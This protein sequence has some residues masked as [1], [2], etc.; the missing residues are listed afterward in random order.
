M[1]A[2]SRVRLTKFAELTDSLIETTLLVLFFLVPLVVVPIT[3]ELFEFNK[4]YLT[5]ALTLVLVFLELAKLMLSPKLVIKTT[6][7]FLPG[8]IFVAALTLATIFSI[9]QQVSLF[10]FYGRFHGGLWSWLAYG[11]IFFSLTQLSTKTYI[12]LVKVSLFSAL[13]VSVWG[14]LEHYGIDSSYWVQDVKARVFSTLG[15]PNWLAAYLAML[16]PWSIIFYLQASKRL[17]TLAWFSLSIT[18]FTCFIF[19]YSRGGNYGLAAGVAGL[20]LLLGLKTLRLQL[21]RLTLLVLAGGLVVAIFA[22]PLASNLFKEP[23]HRTTGTLEG[24]DETGNIRLIVWRGAWEIFLHHPLLGT[25]LETFGESFYQFRPVEMNKTSE[26]D[27][28]FNRA[29]NEYLNYL[30]TTGV[31]GAGAYAGLVGSFFWLVLRF[32]R[33]AALSPERLYLSAALASTTVFLVQNIFSFTVVPLAIV[34]VL[35]FAAVIFVGVGKFSP[36]WPTWWNYQKTKHF[37]WLLFIPSILGLIVVINLWRADIFYT[38]GVS[39]NEIGNAEGAEQNLLK[40]V[41]LNPTEPNYLMQ[42]AFA[43]ANLAS[44]YR[45]S[46]T[47]KSLAKVAISASD[48]AVQISP[49]NLSL[50]RLRAQIYQQLASLD[51]DYRQA[52]E[53]SRLRAVALAPSEPR[54]RLELAQYYF[55]RSK[56]ELALTS[57]LESVRLKPDLVESLILVVQ[58]YQ[59]TGN[60]AAAK[61]YLD[62]ALKIDPTNPELIRLSQKVGP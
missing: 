52:E 1:E 44:S 27:F 35:N 30:A 45:A 60:Y 33:R 13:L 39:N 55:D 25:G 5:Y 21:R 23:A 62:Q 12:S 46:D 58:I 7:L 10:G 8:A 56:T 31:V 29:H 11:V 24:G 51:I 36:T 40:A 54:I 41:Q 50:W 2:L 28:L 17:A 9:D 4:M 26:W 6:R 22:S 47:A 57:G 53:N 37:A 32:I 20:L 18:L 38:K 15:Q 48:T 3:Q 42:L 43:E 59:S 61:I 19:T 14:I 16:I 34:L 49:Q